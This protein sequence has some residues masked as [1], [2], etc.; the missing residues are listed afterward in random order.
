MACLTRPPRFPPF[1]PSPLK[2]ERGISGPGG[3]VSGIFGDFRG[4]EAL[5]GT[6]AVG[7]HWLGQQGKSWACG[8]VDMARLTPS[9][10]SRNEAKRDCRVFPKFPRPLYRGREEREGK[11]GTV[12]SPVHHRKST[13]DNRARKPD[14]GA[15]EAQP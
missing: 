1:F 13:Q 9:R 10:N 15:G 12:E 2:G 14:H 5:P 6:R 11:S 3:T 7:H 8:G 4:L